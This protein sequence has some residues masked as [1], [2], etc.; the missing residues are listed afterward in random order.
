VKVQIL[1]YGRG[2]TRSHYVDN[3][4]LMGNGPDVRQT[5]QWI[6]V[7]VS[8]RVTKKPLYVFSIITLYTVVRQ[9]YLW[10]PLAQSVKLLANGL[11]GPVIEYSLE[12]RSILQ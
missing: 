12:K 10:V 2:S 1:E 8:R 9:S 6:H 5:T 7:T 4:L 3:S 11:C